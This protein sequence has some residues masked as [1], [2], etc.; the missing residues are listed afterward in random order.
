MEFVN[1]IFQCL[2][3]YYVDLWH[4]LVFDLMHINPVVYLVFVVVMIWCVR[5]DRVA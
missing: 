3:D 2:V 5:Q 4:R 1:T